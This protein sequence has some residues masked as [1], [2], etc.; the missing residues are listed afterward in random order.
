[1]IL[2]MFSGGQGAAAALDCVGGEATR[3]VIAS[4]QPGASTIVYGAL[5]GPVL[6]MNILDVFLGKSLKVRCCVPQYR[7]TLYAVHAGICKRMSS[8][9]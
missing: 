4:L 8:V 9:H 6:H 2:L 3:M 7:Q 5:G 1:M